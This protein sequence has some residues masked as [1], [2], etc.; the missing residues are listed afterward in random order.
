LRYQYLILFN[1]IKT[2]ERLKFSAKAQNLA[3]ESGGKARFSFF[4]ALFFLTP[5]LPALNQSISF[6]SQTSTQLVHF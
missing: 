5:T 3:L 2:K 1:K 6:A 4:R